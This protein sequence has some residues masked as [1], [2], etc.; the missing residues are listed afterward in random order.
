M[1]SIDTLYSYIRTGKLRCK[2]TE[3]F[4]RNWSPKG[5]FEHIECI[6][7]SNLGLT[8]LPRLPNATYVD[9]SNNNLTWIVEEHFPKIEMLICRNNNI[10]TM[11]KKLENVII[12]I[13]PDNNI[14]ELPVMPKID[15]L[16]CS[17]NMI[18]N[19]PHMPSLRALTCYGNPLV[20]I[21]APDLEY[22]ECS[23]THV[24]KLGKLNCLKEF[25]CTETEK[26]VYSNWVADRVC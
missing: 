11:P 2:F 13:C 18:E 3:P 26:V 5:V 20:L 24:N 4:D 10:T 22:L 19:L 12:L 23:E 25:R 21:D 1:S 16:D 6:D 9:C 17:D 14:T 15:D 8:V 7:C